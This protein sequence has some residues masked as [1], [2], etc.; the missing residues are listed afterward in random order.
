MRGVAG[1][2]RLGH[3]PFSARRI[4][5]PPGAGNAGPGAAAAGRRGADLISYARPERGRD[6]PAPAG[7]PAPMAAR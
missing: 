4:P 6:S 5:D 3:A 1:A 7:R 2:G